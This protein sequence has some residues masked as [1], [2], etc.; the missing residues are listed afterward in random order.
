M[1]LLIQ[2]ITRKIAT[3]ILNLSARILGLEPIEILARTL[4]SQ[5]ELNRMTWL[6]IGKDYPII[7][8]PGKT[9]GT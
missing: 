3:A 4:E 9:Y 8:T 2:V 1:K 7:T 5:D 6:L